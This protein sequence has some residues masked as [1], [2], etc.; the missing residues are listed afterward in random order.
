MAPIRQRG[1]ASPPEALVLVQN[2]LTWHSRHADFHDQTGKQYHFISRYLTKVVPGTPFVYYRGLRRA[3]GSLRPSAEYFGCGV[4]GQVWEDDAPADGE[5]Q[6]YYCSIL[7]Y[8][9]FREPVLARQDGHWLEPLPHRL[10]FQ[11][12]VRAISAELYQTIVLRGG[13]RPAPASVGTALLP[14]FPDLDEVSPVTAN[15]L[16]RAGADG[17]VSKRFSASSQRSPVAAA[18]G[19]RAEQLVVRYLERTLPHAQARTVEWVARQRLGWDVEYTASP[20]GK[21]AVEVKGT[22]ASGFE[23]VEL[24]AREWEAAERLR[25]RFW[26]YLVADTL[27][28]TPAIQAIRDPYA[29]VAD[30]GWQITPVTWR[31]QPP[32]PA[33]TL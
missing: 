11:A 28:R 23:S 26:L 16:W 17:G 4:I 33:P 13:L 29:L 8:L 2:D 32:H 7:D 12:S 6:R 20:E 5:P 1:G 21:V 31:L 30:G 19:D 14:E 24:T 27:G 22:T 10:S 18:V 3:D 15:N 9:P 25:D